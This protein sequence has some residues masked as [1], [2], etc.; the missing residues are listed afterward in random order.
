MK[1][2]FWV[3]L[4]IFGYLFGRRFL[5][6]LYRAIINFS[7][8]GLG[9]DNMYGESWTGEEWFIKKILVPKKT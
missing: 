3:I 8:H 9:Y 4:N 6:P 7:L 1:Y 2:F 5:A